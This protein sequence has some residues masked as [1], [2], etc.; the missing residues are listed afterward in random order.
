MTLR[1]L[2]LSERDAVASETPASRATSCSVAGVLRLVWLTSAPVLAP[3]GDPAVPRPYR[4]AASG[5]WRRGRK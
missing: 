3:A 5:R 1:V 4:R 2:P